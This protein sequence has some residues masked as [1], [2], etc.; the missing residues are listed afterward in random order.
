MVEPEL[1]E[2]LD[3]LLALTRHPPLVVGAHSTVSGIDQHRFTGFRILELTQ[4]N[5]G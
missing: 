3:L 5:V 1:A 4:A 2:Q